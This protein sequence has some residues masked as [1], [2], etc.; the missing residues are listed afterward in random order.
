MY[1]LHGAWDDR[2]DD[3]NVLILPGE[4]EEAQL[5]SQLKHVEIETYIVESP[6]SLDSRVFLASF[7]LRS[8]GKAL[9]SNVNMKVQSGSGWPLLTS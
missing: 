5:D 6:K 4:L 8:D 3:M 1:R 2:I 7:R 9:D